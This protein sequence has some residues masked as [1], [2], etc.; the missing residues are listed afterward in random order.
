MEL[1]YARLETALRGHLRIDPDRMGTFKSRIKQLQRLGFPEGVNI[2][3]GEKMVYN[4]S[5]LFQLAT[6]FELIGAGLPAD[7]ATKIVTHNWRQFACAFA[8][9]VYALRRRNH[10]TQVWA[11]VIAR[12]FGDLQTEPYADGKM[13]LTSFPDYARVAVGDDSGMQWQL[14]KSMDYRRCHAYILLPIEDL[15]A[16]ILKSAEV[17]GCPQIRLD[18]EFSDW[19]PGQEDEDLGY[20]YFVDT[21]SPWEELTTAKAQPEIWTTA[22]ILQN[23]AVQNALKWQREHA[24]VEPK[25]IIKEMAATIVDTLSEKQVEVLLDGGDDG[26][27]SQYAFQDLVEMS[28]FIKINGDLRVTPLGAAVMDIAL[29]RFPRPRNKP[30]EPIVEEEVTAGIL[31]EHQADD[32]ADGTEAANGND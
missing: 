24:P 21:F 3:R 20:W 16:S 11:W 4:A 2:G 26:W 19:L 17:A 18:P 5:H 8:T 7:R 15:T 10:D 13:D 31:I 1:S 29:E 12:T 27:E 32:A 14:M 22:S 23:R 25:P 28:I 30:E 6:A 9:S